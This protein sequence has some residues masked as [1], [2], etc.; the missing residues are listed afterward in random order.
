MKN[1]VLILILIFAAGGG[2][3]EEITLQK[4]IEQVLEND[5]TLK[6][7]SES[8]ESAYQG[9][10]ISRSQGYP[11]LTLQTD[12]VY[13]AGMRRDYSFDDFPPESR[14]TVSNSFNLG[15][16]LSQLLPTGGVLSTSV[17][18]TFQYNI[19]LAEN[20]LEQSASLKQQ[21]EFTFNYQQP[22]FVNGRLIDGRLL[23]TGNEAAE[24]GWQSSKESAKGT[25]N[26]VLL[27][28]ARL[29]LQLISIQRN[30][31]FLEESL[32][33]AR[34]Q[35]KQA[36]IDREQGRTSENQVL[37]LEVAVNR[38]RE[39]LLD[40]EL[41]QFQAENQ[42]GNM[43]RIRDFSPYSF[44]EAI[45]PLIAAAEAYIEN[46]G[47]QDL[48]QKALAENPEIVAKR[49]EGQSK[50]MEAQ[51]NDSENAANMSLYFTIS[52]RYPDEREDEESFAAS[53]SDFFEED[54]GVNLN[55]GLSFAVPLTDG[56]TRKARR[57]ADESGIRIAELNIS[58]AEKTI[59]EQLRIAQKRNEI[60]RKRAEL[61]K[62]NIEYQQN[63]LQREEQLADLNTTTKL[64]V[65]TV[66]LDLL[67]TQNELWQT[68]GDLFLNLLELTALTGEPL[69]N[70]FPE[71]L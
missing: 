51:V 60:L 10:R 32:L 20:E 66:R 47:S 29:Y 43:V 16:G 27:R 15:I 17:G 41:A 25:K 5:E 61:L 65:D 4:I 9:Y 63:R 46:T 39:A 36:E 52:P 45:E 69:E 18:D 58:A 23:R 11:Q 8:V 62:V 7:A 28:T 56:G 1:V 35:L 3:T 19:Q 6:I 2:F 31:A 13:G 24:L 14:T 48:Y 12:P 26:S 71:G 30:K 50:R 67:S 21:P 33:L 38:Q 70:I 57:K 42:L 37:G 54:S 34:E 64:K 59:A 49:L 53:F 40:V 22:L 68:Q 44:D 55:F